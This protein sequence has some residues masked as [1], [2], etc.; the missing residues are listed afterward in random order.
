MPPPS[1][2]QTSTRYAST[3]DDI[4]NARKSSV[5]EK[6]KQRKTLCGALLKQWDNWTR[7]KNNLPIQ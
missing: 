7:L 3:P 6:K 4:E 2:M 1:F 5:P